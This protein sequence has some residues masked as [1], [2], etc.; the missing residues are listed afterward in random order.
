[1]ISLGI[2]LI[3]FLTSDDL[4]H[5]E[6]FDYN[7]A[8]YLSLVLFIHGITLKTLSIPILDVH[9]MFK[10]LDKIEK[11]SFWSHVAKLQL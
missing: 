8:S 5:S 4:W 3:S 1:M 6:E 10:I 2:K 11:T 7:E 9:P